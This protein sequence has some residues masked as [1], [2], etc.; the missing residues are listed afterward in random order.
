MYMHVF[1]LLQTKLYVLLVFTQLFI[2]VGLQETMGLPS[3]VTILAGNASLYCCY[4]SAGVALNARFTT[5]GMCAK[6]NSKQY[7]CGANMQ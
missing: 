7:I 1:N 2:L 3:L 5:N 6:N 4:L